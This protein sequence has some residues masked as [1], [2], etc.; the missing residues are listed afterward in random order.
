MVC[1]ENLPRWNSSLRKEAHMER[2]VEMDE[3]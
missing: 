2:D 3:V 1:R